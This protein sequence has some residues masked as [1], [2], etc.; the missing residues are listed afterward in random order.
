M[1]GSRPVR[2]FPINFE[3]PAKFSA[4]RTS[5]ETIDEETPESRRRLLKKQKTSNF[6]MPTFTLG[7]FSLVDEIYGVIIVFDNWSYSS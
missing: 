7:E 1:P 4:K 3:I 5:Q 6:E 2:K